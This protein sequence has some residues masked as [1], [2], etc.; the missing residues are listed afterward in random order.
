MGWMGT[1][2]C[3]TGQAM[4]LLTAEIGYKCSYNPPAGQ[5]SRTVSGVGGYHSQGEEMGCSQMLLK[6]EGDFVPPDWKPAKTSHWAAERSLLAAGIGCSVISYCAGLVKL[7]A[8][9]KEN[10][11]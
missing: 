5:S 2:L 11:V 9:P 8:H 6:K 4:L 7:S 1:G 3:R 10:V